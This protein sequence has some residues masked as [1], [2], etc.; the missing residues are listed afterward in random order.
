MSSYRDPD[1]PLVSVVNSKGYTPETVKIEPEKVHALSL[2]AHERAKNSPGTISQHEQGLLG[3][4]ALARHLGVPDAVDTNIYKNGDPG[5]DLDIESGTIDVKTAGKRW[6]NPELFVRVHKRLV[7]DFYVLVQQLNRQMYQII[8]WV[9]RKTVR[10]AP[11]RRIQREGYTDRV[12]AV[13][14]DC[15]RLF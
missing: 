10:E 2:H 8:G 6:N 7:A 13:P 15:L 5:Y 11:V 9:P 14:Q 3:E 4:Y 1:R 12:R